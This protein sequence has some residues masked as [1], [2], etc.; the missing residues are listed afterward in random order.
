V[1]E[2]DAQLD[3]QSLM[4]AKVNT[5]VKQHNNPA[6]MKSSSSMV[7]SGAESVT[8]GFKNDHSRSTLF[9]SV[10]ILKKQI[11]KHNGLKFAEYTLMFCS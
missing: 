7:I 9:N 8:G 1:V 5:N 6:V 11:A 10:K 2:D 3:Q 4:K